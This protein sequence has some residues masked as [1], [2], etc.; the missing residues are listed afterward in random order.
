MKE[1]R[2][3]MG[4]P[5][6]VEIADGDAVRAQ[7]IQAEIEKVF[8]YFKYIDEKFS[9]YKDTSEIMA[10]NRG[11][12]RLEDASGDMRTIFALAEETKKLTDGYFDIQ[13]PVGGSAT[14]PFFDPSGIVKGWA[15]WQ[16]AKI[17]QRDGYRNFYVDAGGDVEV[18]GHKWS[19][20]IKNP[21]KQT[22]I[23]KTL[24]VT[25]AG[26]ATSGTYIR[27]DHIY[28][29]KGA[30]P[31]GIVSLTVIGP[32]IFEAARFA[33]AAFAMGPA[34]INFIEQLDGFEGYIIDSK[35]TATMTSGFERYAAPH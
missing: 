19:I 30:A 20:G 18:H 16:A 9:T 10:I 33:P 6:T 15:I 11:E 29:P 3:L 34:G 25:D 26:I 12:L 7:V 4:M 22:E 27:G 28:N 31:E 21:F 1:T 8:D 23:V 13:K 2:I 35:G 17:L 32:N 14:A 24:Y 5:V